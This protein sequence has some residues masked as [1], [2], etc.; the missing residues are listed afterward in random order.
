[1]EMIRALSASYRLHLLVAVWWCASSMLPLAA[2]SELVIHKDGTKL[3]HRPAC[4]VVAGAKQ[5]ILAMTRAQAESRGYKPHEACDPANP[6][7]P[8]AGSTPG[9]PAAPPT[10]YLDGTR[11]YHTSTCK[12]LPRDKQGVKSASLEVAGK[13]HWPCP[14]CKPPIRKKSD[15]PAVPGTGRGR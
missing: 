7:A 8:S 4:P 6:D 14:T 13:S 2:Q 9:K 5:G 15:A 11:Y 1:M 3:Y 10:V 12:T